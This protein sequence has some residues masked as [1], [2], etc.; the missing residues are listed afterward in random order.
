MSTKQVAEL[1]AAYKKQRDDLLAFMQNAPVSSGVC[2]C[3]DDMERHANPMDCGHR[4][5]D[6]WDHSVLCY[7][8]EVARFDAAKEPA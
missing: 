7:A 3:G 8:E 1:A 6:Q 5:V 2:C 4:P